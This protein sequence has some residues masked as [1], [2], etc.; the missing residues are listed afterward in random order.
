MPWESSTGWMWGYQALFSGTVEHDES[1]TH[2]HTHTHTHRGFHGV[3]DISHYITLWGPQYII[4]I[5]KSLK[6]PAM[7]TTQLKLLFNS[8]FLPTELD[9]EFCF[10]SVYI[11]NPL[12]TLWPTLVEISKIV[13]DLSPSDLGL[14][15]SH[16][17]LCEPES[18]EVSSSLL[19]PHL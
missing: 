5:L 19:F 1:H 2:T 4:C 7:K 14:N 18:N 17:L 15:H 3:T 6:R 9:I 8:A 13:L 16:H 10:T 12:N 11:Q